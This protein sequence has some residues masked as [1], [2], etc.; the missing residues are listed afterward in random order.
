M[1]IICEKLTLEVVAETVRPRGSKPQSLATLFP[2]SEVE[3]SAASQANFH[4]SSQWEQKSSR[5]GSI[6][7]LKEARRCDLSLG[8]QVV[9]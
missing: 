4:R 7:F 2:K 5:T 1:G 9:P 8:I 6:Y 3:T